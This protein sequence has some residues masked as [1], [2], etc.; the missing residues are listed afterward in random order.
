MNLFDTSLD[1][2]ASIL[3]DSTPL[4]DPINEPRTGKPHA[5]PG[6]DWQVKLCFSRGRTTRA[7]PEN[8][9]ARA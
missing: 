1:E 8:V 9:H 2:A 6:K 5:S 7:C 3:H 4:L